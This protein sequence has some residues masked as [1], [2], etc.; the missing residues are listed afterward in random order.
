MTF[1]GVTAGPQ[2]GRMAENQ[3]LVLPV[4]TDMLICASTG[5]CYKYRL[6][7]DERKVHV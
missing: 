1:C 2:A 7:Q 3:T 6:Y 5:G 4:F